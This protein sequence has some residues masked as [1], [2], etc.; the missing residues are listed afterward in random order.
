MKSPSSKRHVQ[1]RE[2]LRNGNFSAAVEL[3]EAQIES[4]PDDPDLLND[5]AT[6][7]H[8]VER[9]N[10]ALQ[11]LNRA[12]TLDPSHE[13]AFYNFIDLIR[14]EQGEMSAAEHFHRMES[15]IPSSPMK[16]QYAA[17]FSAKT[18]SNSSAQDTPRFQRVLCYSPYSQWRIHTLFETTTLHGL[19]HRGA[20]TK[21]VLCDGLYKQCD[22]YR[23]ADRPRHA[24]SCTECQ[25]WAAEYMANLKMPFEWLGRYQ[26]PSDREDARAWASAL[27]PHRFW[28]ASYQDWPIGQWVKSSIHTNLRANTINLDDS[29]ILTIS[30]EF[31]ESGVIAALAIERLLEHFEPDVLLLFSGRFSSTRIAFELARTR[32]IRVLTHERSPRDNDDFLLME[33][34]RVHD[35]QARKRFWSTWKDV[36]L[37]S[38]ELETV[39]GYLEARATDPS[40][41]PFTTLP[42]DSNR[43]QIQQGSIV[44]FTSSEDEVAAESIYS[45]PFNSQTEWILETASIAECFPEVDFYVRI[46]P[47]TSG[48]KAHLGGNRQALQEFVQLKPQLADNVRMIMPDEDINSYALGKRAM[49]CVV[50]H[51][52]LGLEM[53]C[54]GKHV[55]SAADS[56][57]SDL[58]FA[59]TAQSP[60]HYRTLLTTAIDSTSFFDQD[61]QR[62]ALRF[63]YGYFFRQPVDFPLIEIQKDGLTAHGRP[64]YKNTGELR[65]GNDRHL[66]RVCDIVLN[67]APVVPL[68]DGSQSRSIAAE[69]AWLSSADAEFSLAQR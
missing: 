29:E 24:L 3:L 67:G 2:H 51:S 38:D 27:P 25:S 19:N 69:D 18:N 17:G 64:R 10:R 63:A 22:L 35:L 58:D 60:D 54:Q 15:S 34:A 68:P 5:A 55:I 50:Y 33:N 61:V 32:G 39:Y 7:L 40:T 16:H 59:H 11:L 48:K 44:L 56:L 31:L 37:T 52:T 21:Y 42:R 43:G 45:S 23:K 12:L 9:T 62:L 13:P 36:P 14:E 41:N 26:I 65:P 20:T 8:H 4:E 1:A 53:A 49:A 30:R 6:A 47:N 66:D 28:D 57:V 46:H